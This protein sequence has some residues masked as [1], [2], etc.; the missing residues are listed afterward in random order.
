MSEELDKHLR[1]ALRPVNPGPGFPDAVMTRIGAR[2]SARHARSWVHAPAWRWLS[3]AAAAILVVV[4]LVHV[5][6]V[7]HT[8]EGLAARQALLQALQVTAKSL[9]LAKRA[10]NDSNAPTGAPDSGA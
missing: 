9:E 6:Q 2:E 7:R 10:V 3:G 4:L 8:R 1:Q 5:Q